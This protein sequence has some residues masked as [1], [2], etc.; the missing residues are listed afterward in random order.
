MWI[1]RL[2][3]V[4]WPIRQSPWG[5]LWDAVQIELGADGKITGELPDALKALIGTQ[6][7]ETLKTK[8]KELS[9]KAFNEGFQKGNAK[10]AEELKPH[11]MDPAER[12]RVKT[13]EKELEDRKIADLEQGK[14]YEEAGKIRDE[15]HAKEIAEK[16]EAIAKRESKLRSGARSEIKAAA[17]KYGARDESLDELAAILGGEIDFDEHLDPFVKDANGKPAVDA[18]NQPM[19]IEGRV[20]AYLDSHRHHVK[21]S[22]GQGG[23][24]RGGAS[25]DNLSDDV[26]AAQTKVAAAEKALA[27]DP[28]N[29]T[30]LLDLHKAQQELN[31]AKS[32]RK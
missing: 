6:V 9:D 16:N 32:G 25:F 19:T 4:P 20:R 5:Y 18:K 10:K 29:N 13:L 12:E 28:R 2:S 14:K 24:A 17:L 21:G 11:L 7:A 8:E 30:L 15:R 22:E 27:D 31:R 1:P 26:Q 3:L 23:G